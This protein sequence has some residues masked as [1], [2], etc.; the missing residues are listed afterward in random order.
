M[1]TSISEQTKKRRRR[2]FFSKS[3]VQSTIYIVCC[4]F[5]IVSFVSIAMSMCVII[6]MSPPPSHTIIFFV[7]CIY[8]DLEATDLSL[9][10]LSWWLCGS[11]YWLAANTQERLR[12]WLQANT[13]NCL[14]YV[15][16]CVARIRLGFFD[17]LQIY[18]V[19]D[20]CKMCGVIDIFRLCHSYK[21]SGLSS[22]TASAG[23][24]S[25]GS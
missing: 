19:I 4:A 23:M 9:D 21:C 2:I 12:Y 15:L 20:M 11:C 25:I 24:L 3:H 17:K 6:C 16:T 8:I 10:E 5:Y 14:G 1:P 7:I 18:I 22:S 13:R